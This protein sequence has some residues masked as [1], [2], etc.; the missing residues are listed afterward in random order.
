ML[1][2]PSNPNYL[3]NAP[4]PNTTI[5]SFTVWIFQ[6]DTI[7]PIILW[8]TT[9]LK[10]LYC[11]QSCPTLCD[12]LDCSPP[13]SSAHGIVQA[14]MLQQVA[15]S[16]SRGSSPPRDQTHIS[17]TGRQ[18]LCPCASWE[19][20]RLGELSQFILFLDSYGFPHS[21][22][23]GWLGVSVRLRWVHLVGLQ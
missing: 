11:V 9:V 4:Y 5:L 18:I 10:L 16:S 1:V 21:Q 6:G 17:Y 20:H 8:D 15:I 13:G 23:P 22:Y 19:A 2:T 7:Q 12:P 14:S 3:L